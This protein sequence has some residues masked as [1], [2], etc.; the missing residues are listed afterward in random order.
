M[1]RDDSG[2][3]ARGGPGFTDPDDVP[4]VE[5]VRRAQ[6]GDRQALE[7]LFQRYLPILRRWAA[8]RLPRWARDLVDTDD[9][10]QETMVRTFQNIE[11]FVPRHDGAFGAYLRQAL[12]NRIRDEVRKAQA[13]PRREEMPHDHPADGASPLEEAI[14]SDALQR[15]EQALS[16][17]ENDER[18]V[19]LARIEMGLTYDEIAAAAHRPSAEA[20]RKAVSRALLRLATE[21]ARE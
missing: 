15:Y 16:R 1:N 6:A 5:L 11:G 14:G 10:I 7:R 3:G 20:A 8:G 17:L 21:M 4:S 12:L 9:M 13:R 18:E 19:V 2:G